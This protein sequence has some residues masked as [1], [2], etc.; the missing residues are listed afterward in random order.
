MSLAASER[1]ST[2]WAVAR[3]PEPISPEQVGRLDDLAN[4]VAGRDMSLI[5]RSGDHR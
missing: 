3:T 2:A 1:R 5:M 4:N